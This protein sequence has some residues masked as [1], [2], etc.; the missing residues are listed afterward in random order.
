MSPRIAIIKEFV[1]ALPKIF[2]PTRE[3]SC[4]LIAEKETASSG[5]LVPI[6]NIKIPIKRS[7][8]LNPSAIKTAE[9]TAVLDDIATTPNA[10]KKMING[11]L[12]LFILKKEY[13]SHRKKLRQE[14][15][16]QITCKD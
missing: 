4:F 14:I 16:S 6:E 8:I 9:S 11:H 7:G 12:I 5:K 1:V 10:K 13:F 2:P 3:V 15:A